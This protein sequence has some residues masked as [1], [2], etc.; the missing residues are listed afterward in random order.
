[1]YI[2]IIYLYKYIPRYCCVVVSVCC[3]LFVSAVAGT[4]RVSIMLLAC[5]RFS[6]AP[7]VC[8]PWKLLSKLSGRFRTANLRTTFL[9]F[10]GFD[11]SRILI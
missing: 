6:A 11:S 10:R 4:M 1:M 9:D 8:N 3:H 2:N 7:P 5:C